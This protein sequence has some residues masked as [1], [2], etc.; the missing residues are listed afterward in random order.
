MQE[1]SQNYIANVGVCKTS[2][3]FQGFFQK[4][5]QKP[6]YMT[7]RETVGIVSLDV[8]RIQSAENKCLIPINLGL[9]YLKCLFI[10]LINYS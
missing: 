7:V 1:E 6:Q 4:N 8:C 10:M 9:G 3:L 5:C 2:P